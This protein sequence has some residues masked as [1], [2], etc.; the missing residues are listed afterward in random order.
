LLLTSVDL[1][2]A[3]V[4]VLKAT[5]K[6]LPLNSGVLIVCGTGYL[7]P[8]AKAAIGITEPRDDVDLL[9]DS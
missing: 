6:E 5:A 4:D 9:R 7:M 8:E 2:E 1:S 3:I